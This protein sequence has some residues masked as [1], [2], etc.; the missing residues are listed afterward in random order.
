MSL[1]NHRRTAFQPLCSVFKDNYIVVCVLNIFQPLSL[2]K[3]YQ[4]I[5]DGFGVA[6]AVRNGANFF[7]IRKD[8][9][10]VLSVKLLHCSNLL[11]Y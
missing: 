3:G 11:E 8:R 6:G 10:G 4:I 5:A 9:S 7:K 2:C 1:D